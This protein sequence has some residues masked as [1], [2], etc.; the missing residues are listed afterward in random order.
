MEKCKWCP[1]RS[2]WK[3]DCSNLFFCQKHVEKHLTNDKKHLLI[4]VRNYLSLENRLKLK[5]EISKRQST[6]EKLSSE[7]KSITSSLISRLTSLQDETLSKIEMLKSS[8]PSLLDQEEYS[9]EDSERV[10][11]LLTSV[12]SFALPETLNFGEEIISFY[13][14]P[15]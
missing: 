8:Y 2:I 7:I 4:P 3:C 14:V 13:S 1:T 11:S 15:L 9:D 12:L 10:E 6:L 5:E